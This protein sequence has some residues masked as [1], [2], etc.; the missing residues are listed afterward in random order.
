MANFTAKLDRKQWGIV[1]GLQ[2]KGHVARDPDG[3]STA[4]RR[5]CGYEK[6]ILHRSHEDQDKTQLEGLVT[7]ENQPFEK[8]T[9]VASSHAVPARAAQLLPADCA[10]GN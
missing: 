8:S 2:R 5:V 7:K 3:E 9:V 6:R 1:R 10:G 4:A